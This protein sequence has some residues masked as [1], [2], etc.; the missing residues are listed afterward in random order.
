MSSDP[1]TPDAPTFSG[2]GRTIDVFIAS[3][4][5]LALLY[6]GIVAHH[7]M[8]RGFAVVDTV[9]F[10]IVS[11]LLIVTEAKS[12]SIARHVTGGVVTPSWAFAFTL[13]LLG[14]PTGAI[15]VMAVATAIADTLS[16]RPIYK[17]VFN[18]AQISLSL[19]LGGL[20][21]MAFGIR[22]PLFSEIELETT[23]AAAMILSGIVVFA[24]NGVI[25]CRL[26]AWLES[27]TFF[28]VLRGQF[29]LSM[30]SDA[31]MLAIAPIFL[32]TAK[33][34]LLML[35]L[36]G[37]ATFFV[38]QTAQNALRRTHEANHD[39][40]TQLLNR[41]AFT[42][43]VEEFLTTADPR[44]HNASLFLLDL[45][46]FKE[47]NDRLGHRTGDHVLQQFANRLAA[48]LPTDAVVARL[49]GDEFA[50][51][52]TGLP[53]ADAVAIAE[54]SK[55]RLAEPL[56]V[57]GF[58]ITAGTS[59]GVSHFPEHGRT[60]SDL[61]HAADVAMYRAKR[62]RSGVEV[63]QAFGAVQDKGRVTLL[64]D[65]ADGLERD[66]FIVEYQPQ[67]DV[68]DGRVCSVEAL[69]R[70][71]HPR[72]GRTLPGEFIALAEH[73]DLIG[74]LTDFVIDRAITEIGPFDELGLAINVSARSLED[75]HF[76]SDLLA[77]L[78]SADFDP[79]RLD[80]EIT[81]S[82]LSSEP[83]RASVVLD[84]LRSAGVRISIDDFGTG[85]SSF[86]TLR[87]TMVDRIKLD[88]SLVT[89]MTCSSTDTHIVKTL[90]DLAHGIALDVVA[91]GVESEEVWAE[92]NRLGCDLAQGFWLSSAVPAERLDAMIRAGFDPVRSV[93][94]ATPHVGTVGLVA[95]T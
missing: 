77:R 5:A 13:M 16:G 29:L 64:G 43:A 51:M 34:N 22:G 41:R 31:A 78:A 10:V 32:I 46:R 45:D 12:T 36:M 2:L 9:L 58:P 15:V 4:A 17:I 28:D 40:L 76:A 63:Y 57:D 65:V 52:I 14:S 44:E 72:H 53:A 86:G 47:V 6:S 75:R 59:I 71:N 87:E 35:P 79:N 83:E 60:Q 42:A 25:I 8:E 73:T 23:R 94:R 91:E 38:Y 70:W 30:T 48:E 26:I 18:A 89:N 92:L 54:Q 37:T 49:G 67:V 24:V 61:L 69:L 84:E 19:A 95:L 11:V 56:T 1:H 20:V 74:P 50:V 82:A 27:A 93:E 33:N 21:L 66:E 80:I 88:R 81:E 55:D 7:E 3:I 62:Y 90:I 85:Y 68:V 39:P